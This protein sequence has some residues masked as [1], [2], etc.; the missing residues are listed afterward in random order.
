MVYSY[1]ERF[2]LHCGFSTGE[3]G[4]VI[5]LAY[6]AAMLLQPLLSQAAD[7][8]ARITLKSGISACALLG[9]ALAVLTPVSMR[10]PPLL[11]VVFGA[12]TCVTLSMQPL[13]NAVGFH[14]INRGEPV[15]FSFARGAGSVAYALSSL[16]LG[17]LASKNIDHILWVYLLS[18]LGLFLSALWFAPHRT[19]RKSAAPSGSVFSVIRKYPRLLLFCA[20]MLILNVP[21]VFINSY[22]A[23]ITKVT[24]GEMSVMIAIAALVE[25][26]SM[27]AYSHLRKRIGDRVLLLVS[28]SFYLVKTGLLALAA[29]V[30]VGT[31]AV[32]VSFATQMLCYAVFIPASSYFANA[33]VRE[34][35][36]VK[37]QML[38][39][40]T[41][42]CSGMI[43]MLLGGLSIQRFGVPLTLLL[44][45]GFV[46]CGILLI[47]PAL[48]Y[49]KRT[50]L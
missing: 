21:H 24:G 32:F 4:L 13:V 7:R 38:L 37:G 25:F 14:F 1:A 35:D 16:L 10:I 11:A 30:P 23:S 15:D 34:A 26:P 2:L 47:A 27:M 3:I 19:E 18:N 45:E 28:A 12:M 33:S 46:L 17:Y 31:W 40:E 39:T 9:A 22:L 42:L 50:Q 6:L 41:T 29:Y 36:Q 48:F 8:E 20:G 49:R 43:S 5:A 44:C